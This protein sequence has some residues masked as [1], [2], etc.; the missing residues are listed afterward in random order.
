MSRAALIRA[1][2]KWRRNQQPAGVN[3]S[4]P[5]ASP[6]QLVLKVALS[7]YNHHLLNTNEP[8]PAGPVKS[9][10]QSSPPAFNVGKLSFAIIVRGNHPVVQLINPPAATVSNASDNLDSNWNSFFLGLTE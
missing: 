2:R 8:T 7:T 5:V 1:A 9:T 10:H 4:A 3:P 6:M